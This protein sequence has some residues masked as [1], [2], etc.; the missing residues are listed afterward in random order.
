[1]AKESS[2]SATAD[3][4]SIFRELLSTSAETSAPS[5]TFASTTSISSAIAAFIAFSAGVEPAMRA[6]RSRSRATASTPVK[7]CRPLVRQSCT[8]HPT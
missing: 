4:M 1:L 5:S 2:C 3:A 7:A 6:S 8:R